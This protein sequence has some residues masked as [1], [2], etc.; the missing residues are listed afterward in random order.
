MPVPDYLLRA[1]DLQRRRYAGDSELLNPGR[2]DVAQDLPQDVAE[3]KAW[4][5]KNFLQKVSEALKRG[6]GKD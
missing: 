1:T 2:Y 3:H 5:G 4:S 6:N